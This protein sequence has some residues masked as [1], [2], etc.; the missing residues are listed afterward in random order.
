MFLSLLN[1]FW[2]QF[3]FFCQHF[4]FNGNLLFHQCM[5]CTFLF[6][7]FLDIF[8]VLVRVLLFFFVFKLKYSWRPVLHYFPVC[9]TVIG[10]GYPFCVCHNASVT[11]QHC[12]SSI[13][14]IL[15]AVAFILVIQ[16]SHN[17]KFVFPTPLPMD[18]QGCQSFVTK[19]LHS[20]LSYTSIFLCTYE[21]I[22][23]Q[24]NC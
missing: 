20:G 19:H 21:Q 7:D 24:V 6:E 2:R 16:S 15:Y 13:V 22:S 8:Y 4:L 1:A 12:Y 3:F 14:C 23:Y 5:N 10:R 18:I 11:V 9:N 17:W